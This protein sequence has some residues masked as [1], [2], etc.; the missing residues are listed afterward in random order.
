MSGDI[1][2][3]Q[4]GAIF[5]EID[6]EQI[7]NFD[8]TEIY[9]ALIQFKA[10]PRKYFNKL[11]LTIR[12][13][14]GDAR[15]IFEIPEIR[16]YITFLDKCFPYWF[17]F[18]MRN[19]PAKFYPGGIILSCVCK[20]EEISNEGSTKQVKFNIDSYRSFI[21]IHFSFFNELMENNGHSEEEIKSISYEI[22]K[23]I[24]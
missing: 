18:F 12:G 10:E 14:D 9:Q 17:Y 2:L 19:I 1:D 6:K 24:S 7:T 16:D 8:F 4:Y 21:E 22:F 20:I 11:N 15:E 13:Y 3:S 23:L 5:L